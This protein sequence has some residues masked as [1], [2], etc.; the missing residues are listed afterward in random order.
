MRKKTLLLAIGLLVI[1]GILPGTHSEV[2][3]LFAKNQKSAMG[4]ASYIT[5]WPQSRHISE[6]RLLYDK[7]T[8][9][10]IKTSPSLTAL[11]AYLEKFPDGKFITDAKIKIDEINWQKASSDN[12]EKAYK[13]YLQIQRYG[14]YVDKASQ[15]YDEIAWERTKADNSIT[16]F[17]LYLANNLTG[18]NVDDAQTEI[19]KIEKW[20]QV[21]SDNSSD[22]YKTYIQNYPQSRF[23]KEARLKY[24][25][26]LWEETDK[27]GTLAAYE[28]YMEKCP[29]G[30]SIKDATARI[31]E[32]RQWESACNA[33]IEQSY[34]TY[35][36]TYPNGR[37]FEKAALK[38]EI[39]K[40]ESAEKSNAIRPL[41][42]YI[43]TYPQGQFINEAHERQQRLI[44]NENPYRSAV[45]KGT[46][47]ALTDFLNSFPGH[48]YQ[49]F[50][51]SLLASAMANWENGGDI[52][53]A[54]TA[55]GWTPETEREMVLYWVA[56]RKKGQL[57]INWD[58]S[59]KVLLEIIR[60]PNNREALSNAVY[61]L[62]GLG[63]DEI[64][65][66][67]KNIMET[68]G[69]ENLA[70]SY[71]NCSN[72]ILY[73]SAKKWAASNGYRIK[74]GYFGS[75]PVSWGGM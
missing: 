9:E 7:F 32:I 20:E 49:I 67:L 75:K 44:N 30:N 72:V 17:K 15:R 40:W 73:N 48:K 2:H 70:E 66:V 45:Q 26:R 60:N 21:C 16:A 74:S 35:I 5:R 33:N 65:P 42:Q 69:S 23:L 50:V 6:A 31:D 25:M 38:I 28:S 53:D 56:K 55:S 62:V 63:I 58:T 51:Q 18:K 57:V 39:L 52:A 37:F 27:S 61:A 54:L 8:W 59:Q 29:Q 4:Y 3:W 10:E 36:N 47:K 34:S 68:S 13:T 64:L 12:T 46:T 19:N 11:N 24:D 22:S 43:A 71:L 41:A 14:R 1:V